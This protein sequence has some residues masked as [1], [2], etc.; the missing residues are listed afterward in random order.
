MHI[1][2]FASANIEDVEIEVVAVIVEVEA[3]MVEIEAGMVEIEAGI[4]EVSRSGGNFCKKFWKKII[5]FI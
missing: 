3:G 2:G 5:Y 1:E 4:I